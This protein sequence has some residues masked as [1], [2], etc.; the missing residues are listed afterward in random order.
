MNAE[1]T[2]VCRGESVTARIKCGRGDTEGF[3]PWSQL[4]YFYDD[5]LWNLWHN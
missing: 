1:G 2:G 5:K 4:C 3:F